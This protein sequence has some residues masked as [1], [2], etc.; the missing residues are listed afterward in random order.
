MQLNFAPMVEGY[1]TVAV[2]GATATVWDAVDDML[3]AT[4]YRLLSSVS[5]DSVFDPNDGVIR[6]T[7]LLQVVEPDEAT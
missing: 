6:A 5:H 3:T 4:G 1:L 7:M 2:E